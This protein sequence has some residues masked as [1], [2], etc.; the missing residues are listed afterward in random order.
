MTKFSLIRYIIILTLF[1]SPLTSNANATEA[2]TFVRQVS[3]QAL[4][5]I[6]TKNVPEEQKEERLQRLFTKSVDT[7]WIAKFV[8]GRYWRDATSAQKEEYLKLHKQFLVNSYVPKFKEYT[9]QK[10]AFKKYYDEG[11]NEYL[12]ETEIVQPNGPAIKVDYKVRKTADGEYKIF[13]IIAEGVS[14][15]TTQRSEFS[16]ILSRKGIDD[17]IKKLRAKV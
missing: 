12:V 10:I 5:L 16:S 4:G 6:K 15:I 13:D 11:D 9:N 14:F 17:L 8:L 2:Q 3:D 7:K 1:I